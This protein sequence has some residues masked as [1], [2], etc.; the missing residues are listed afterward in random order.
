M[1]INASTTIKQGT[2]TLILEGEADSASAPRIEE[3]IREVS[4]SP[5]DRLVLDLTGLTYLSSAGLRCLVRAHQQLGRGVE[6][7]LVNAS[8]EVAETIRLTG[9]S[10][11]V[12]MHH[13]FRR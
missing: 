5:L 8:P 10:D 9:F 7:V 3:L 1:S 12:T 6:I 2:A 4:A 13:Q 11:S